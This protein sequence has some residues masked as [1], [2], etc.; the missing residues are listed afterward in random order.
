MPW[1]RKAS[2]KKSTKKRSRQA[3]VSVAIKPPPVSSNVQ[4]RHKFRFNCI[5]GAQPLITVNGI[6]GACGTICTTTNSV[7]T[8]IF[9]SFKIHSIEMWGGAA[10][11]T[12][13]SQVS[14]DWAPNSSSVG[15]FYSTNIQQTDMSSTPAYPAHVKAYP[16]RGSAASF[17]CSN[18]NGSTDGATGVVQLNFNAATIVDLDISLVISDN[19]FANNPI[20]VGTATLANEY[21]LYLDWPTSHNMTPFYVV[22]TF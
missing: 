8:P 20:T 22:S 21:F 2:T 15:Q 17:W 12:V 18:R 16:P 6:L 19:D 10:T 14:V 7:C 3:N 4:V 11:S 1:K 5:A 9:A 13:P